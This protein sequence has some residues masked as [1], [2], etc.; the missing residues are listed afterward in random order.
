MKKKAKTATEEN[1]VG[2]TAEDDQAELECLQATW[3]SPVYGF[4]KPEVKVVY[5]GKRKAH[6]FYCTAKKCK[7][8]GYVKRYQ[9]SK[10][11]SA[12]SNLKTHAMK[13]FGEDVIKAAFTGDSATA[14]DGSIFAAFARQGQ[15]PI[16]VSHRAL[17]SDETRARIALWCA[18]SSRPMKIVR[19]RQFTTLMLAGRPTTTIPSPT[20]IS[21]DIKAAFEACRSRIDNILWTGASRACPLCNR[22]MDLAQPSRYGRLDRASSS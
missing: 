8:T 5:D 21:R 4:F 19:D 1:E 17:T 10:D 15:Q 9:D 22:C 20:T 3:R 6:V 11:R 12:T 14:R 16:S 2:S 13:C 18:E 7:T